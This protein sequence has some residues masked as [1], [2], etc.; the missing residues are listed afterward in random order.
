[1]K[2]IVQIS[3]D[4]TSIPE[5]LETAHLA[6]R[7]GVDWLE[8]G[9]PLIIAE[10]MN[11][12]RA[13]RAEFSGIPIVADLKTMD[14]GWLEAQMMAK[15]GATHVVVME[16]AHPETIKVVVQ[17]GKDFGVKVMGDNLG[18]EDMVAAA[19]RLEDFGCD[20]VIHHIGY[21][22]RRGLAA[23]GKPWPSPLDQL[24]E[25]VAAVRVP[26]QSVG[27]LSIEQAIRAPEY[28]APLVVLGAPLTIDADSFKAASGNLEETLRLICDR[29]HA[30]GN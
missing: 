27:G 1:M 16:R 5:A 17:A 24:R 28:G 30:Y 20:F 15:A 14:G 9:T 8:A 23:A 11:G 10:G 18:A 13:L 19:K 29:V 3:L 2:P 7:S 21:D 6:M 22:Q 12:V 4:L 25:V 26:V